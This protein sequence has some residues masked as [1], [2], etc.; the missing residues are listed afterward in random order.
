MCGAC[1]V[2]KSKLEAL[3]RINSGGGAAKH[4]SAAKERAMR[5]VAFLAFSALLTSG[6]TYSFFQLKRWN[7]RHPEEWLAVVYPGMLSLFLAV[8]FGILSLVFAVLLAIELKRIR[9]IRAMAP[10]DP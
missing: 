10:N 2:A 7:H 4:I 9:S 3:A 8:V 1:W 5:Y 6:F